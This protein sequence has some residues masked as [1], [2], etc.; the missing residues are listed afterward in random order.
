[1]MV[2]YTPAL[3]I[4]KYKVIPCKKRRGKP[5]YIHD[6]TIAF[7]TETTTFFLVNGDWKS[8]ADCTEEEIKNATDRLGMIYAWAFKMPGLTV[9]GRTRSELI[10]FISRLDQENPNKKIIWVHNLNYDY[11]FIS[12]IL[13]PNPANEKPVISRAKM[14]PLKIDVFGYNI[15]LRDSYALCNM[16]LGKVGEAYNIGKKLKGDLDYSKAH[17][18]NTP[19]TQEE[20]DYI[21]RDVDILYEYIEN[22]WINQYNRN[23][24]DLPMTQTGVPRRECKKLLSQDKKH[25]KHMKNIAP[26]T[27][28]EYENL[29]EPFAGGVAHCNFLYTTSDDEPTPNIVRNVTSADRA[30]SYPT[31]AATR[32]FPSSAFIKMQNPDEMD[33][34]EEDHVYIALVKFTNL[35]QKMAWDYISYSKCHD[36][37]VNAVV[38]N[39]RVA[40]ADSLTIKLTNID[41]RII[42]NVYNYDDC[43]ILEAYVA[44]ADYL[45]MPFIDYLLTLYENKTKLKKSNPALYLRSKQLLNSLYGMLCTDICKEDIFFDNGEWIMEYETYVDSNGNPDEAKIRMAMA[46]KL[47]KNNPFLPYSVGVFITAYAR[48]QLFEPI[49]HFDDSIGDIDGICNDA[50]YTDT[51][52]V[53]FVNAD[54]N[55]KYI[56]EYN[57]KMLARLHRVANERNIPYERFA[58]TDPDGNPHPLGVFEADGFYDEFV[59]M[60]SKKYCYKCWETNKKTGEKEY[61]FHFTVAG[62]Q[63]SY[64]DGTGEHPTMTSMS[65]MLP[66]TVIPKGRTN[67]QYSISQPLVELTDYLGNKYVNDYERGVAM[68]RTSYTFGLS[69][70][71][72]E[73]LDDPLLDLWQD[74]CFNKI[75]SPL[76]Q[77]AKWKKE[78]KHD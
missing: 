34:Y 43:E 7:D 18:P 72:S 47:R 28:E 29:H 25:M 61:K 64:V 42:N 54:I 66:G 65:Q 50:V 20:L 1:M 37:P 78:G 39:G 4:P 62:L 56:E 75:S 51:D 26:S 38:D 59:S 41:L 71:Y 68:W 57:E 8:E 33:I 31:E 74:K 52:S 22:E 35:Q 17:L 15:E 48:E 73:L 23:W 36:E 58:P 3:K 14:A 32:K 5:E 53:K 19:L 55:L 11:S 27:V 21:E 77:V 44:T 67:Y 49:V 70:D 76:A 16:G 13:E 45:P 10:Q 63:K 24:C 9:I 46:E 60:G 6:A 30:S 40:S 12:D 2:P 69:N